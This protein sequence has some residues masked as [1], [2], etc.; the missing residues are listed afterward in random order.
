MTDAPWAARKTTTERP[1]SRFL[2]NLMRLA[3]LYTLVFVALKLHGSIDWSWW[4]VFAPV[5]GLVTLIFLGGMV[6]AAAGG[7][8]GGQ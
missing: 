2:P 8:R 7:K 4:A 6:V 3:N 1:R 5:L